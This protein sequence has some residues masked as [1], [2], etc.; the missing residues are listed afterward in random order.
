M[1]KIFIIAL[2]S[3]IA[4][5]SMAMDNACT[6][7]T[8]DDAQQ[9]ITTRIG[10][11][12]AQAEPRLLYE[13][14]Q[15][16]VQSLKNTNQLNPAAVLSALETILPDQERFRFIGLFTPITQ[17][18]LSLKPLDSFAISNDATQCAMVE[19]GG[20]LR[21]LKEESSKQWR[22]ITL[23]EVGNE[24]IQYVCWINRGTKLLFAA[25]NG[26]DGYWPYAFDAQTMA[27]VHVGQQEVDAA[28]VAIGQQPLWMRKFM[29]VDREQPS[30]F[31]GLGAGKAAKNRRFDLKESHELNNATLTIAH[32]PSLMEI[33]QFLCAQAQK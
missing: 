28:M 26:Q 14:V 1:K 30:G 29:K 18:T 11:F 21:V 12:I 24:S 23:A 3:F 16:K 31:Y 20:V 9:E 22:N 27:P 5:T 19:T 15:A 13:A 17:V 32:H 2:S 33:A 10:M 8:M 7:M 6:S 25:S 4:C